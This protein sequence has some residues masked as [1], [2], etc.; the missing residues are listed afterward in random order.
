M[1][2]AL[3]LALLPLLG[4][5]LFPAAQSPPAEVAHDL[6]TVGS[7]PPSA[8]A[9]A[10]GST[11]PSLPSGPGSEVGPGNGTQR[12]LAPGGNMGGEGRGTSPLVPGA[13]PISA[14]APPARSSPKAGTVR[15]PLTVPDGASLLAQ[16]ESSLGG[17]AGP[18][19]GQTLSCEPV[20]VG[21][22]AACSS[23]RAVLS[24]KLPD[25]ASTPSW[26]ETVVPPQRS[27]A[28]MVYDAADGYVLLYGGSNAQ[29]STLTDTWKFLGGVWTPLSPSTY[30]SARTEESMTYDSVD[31]Y[32][33]LFGGLY[34]SSTYLGDTWKFVGGSW[35][36]L[37]SSCTITAREGAAMANDTA[38]GYVVL[39]GGYNGGY[40][41]DT[42]KFTGVS[43]TAL[44]PPTSPPARA[45]AAITY[46]EGDKYVVAY[47]GYGPSLLGD[48]WEFFGGS[49]T[50]ICSGLTC[51]LTARA[52]PGMAYDEVDRHVVLFGGSRGGAIS[53]TWTYAAGTWTQI[54]P[55]TPP[56]PRYQMGA[57]YDAQDGYVLLFAG[58]GPPGY[59][60]DTWTFAS[61]SWTTLPAE[62]SP[63]QRQDAS[64]T[65]DAA[66]G[67]VLLFGGYTR[68]DGM[69]GYNFVLSDTWKFVAGGWTELYPTSWPAGR[70]GAAMAYDA[71]DGY[72][73]LYGGYNSSG[74]GMYYDDT[75]KYLAG[76]WTQ[77]CLGCGPRDEYS[78]FTFDTIDNYLVAFGGTTGGPLQGT[79]KFSGGVWSTLGPASS[80]TARWGAA[81]AY[82]PVDHYVLLFGGYDGT[83][84]DGD[85]WKFLGG[86]WTS[87]GPSPVP[88]ARQGASMVGD[89]ADEYVVLF[90]G[91]TGAGPLS[92]TWKWAGN[93]WTA[94]SP[95]T[96]PPP[97]FNG[98]IADDVA[99]GY[100]VLFSGDDG[101]TLGD[102]WELTLPPPTVSAPTPSQAAADV[103]Q[104]FS[105]SA[106][107]NGGTGTYPTYTWT[108]SSVNLGCTLV[109]APSISCTPTVVGTSYTVSVSVTDSAG[110]SS[111]VATS[112]AYT[113][114]ADPTVSVP[115]GSPSSGGIDS[116]ETVTFSATSTPGSGGDTYVWNNLPTGCLSSSTLSLPCDP[117]TMAANATFLVSVTIKD[118]NGF[119][120]TGG[121]LSYLVHPA[122]SPRVPLASPGSGGVDD[123]Q[124]VTFS[125]GATLGTGSYTLWSWSGLPGCTG[126]NAPVLSCPTSGVVT[127]TTFTVAVTVTDSNGA[128]GTASLSYLVHPDP[129]VTV[130]AGTPSSVDSGGTVSFSEVATLGSGSYSWAWSG[131]PSSCTSQDLRVLPC[132][133]TGVVAN[134]TFTI[135]ATVTDSNGGSATSSSL[136][137]TVDA[138]PA[139]KVPVASSASGAVDSGQAVVF[140]TGATL[141]T[142]SYTT[143]GWSG[144]PGCPSSNTPVLSCLTGGVISNT[145]FTVTVTVT[146]SN[147]GSG[148]ASL[149]YLVHPAPVPSGISASPTSGGVDNGQT[150]TLSSGASLGTGSYTTWTWSGLPGCAPANSPV[151]SC[152]A[153][154]VVA[155]T[156]Y[157][158]SLVVTDSNGG[159]GTTSLV[160][161]VHPDP[162]VSAPVG[163]TSSVD[164]GQ[165]VAFSALATLGTG[166][167]TWSWSGL[168]TS[169]SS[170]DLRVLPCVP[171]GLAVNTTFSITVSVRDSNGGGAS[172]TSLSYTVEADPSPQGPVAAPVSGGVD[173]GQTVVFSSGGTLG[174][175]SYSSWSWSGLPGCPS[176]SSPVLSCTTSGVVANTSYT[177]VVTVTDSNG[178]SGMA[179][180]VYLVLAAPLPKVPSASPSS[181]GVDDGQTVT[182]STGATLGTGSYSFSWSGLPG[183]ASANT[184]VLTCTTSGVALNTTFSIVVVATDTNGGSGSASLFYLVHPDPVA[185]AP[186]ATPPSG[187]ADEGQTV[188]FDSGATLGTGVYSSWSWSGLPGC[189][190][191]NAPVVTCAV[192][193]VSA[194][195]TFTVAVTVVDSDGGSATASLSYLVHA[196]PVAAVPVASPGSGAV[197]DGQT[198]VLTTGA[199]QGT[200][201]YSLWSWSGLPG[202]ASVNAPTLSCT[203][204]GVSANTTYTISVTVTD[205]NG[206]SGSASLSYLVHPAPAPKAISASPA[207]GGVDAGQTVVFGSGASLGTGAYTAW[208][209]SGL[210]GCTSANL[211]VLS[212]TTGGLAVNTSY[213]VQIS[214]L[215]SNG[216][217]G[218]A[219]L[220]YLVLADPVAKVPVAAPV[221]GGVDNGQTVTFNAGATQGSGSYTTWS[222]S[223]LPGCSGANSPVLS[224]ATAG[225]ASNTTFTVAVTVSDSNGGS[226]TASLSY[227]VHPDPAITLPTGSPS[228]IDNGGTVQFSALATLGSGGYVWS[229][230]GL[231]SSC[232]SHDLRVLPCTPTGILANTT[233]SITATATDSNGNS[234]T[235]APFAYTVDSDPSIAGA[236]ASPD[237][238]DVGVAVQLSAS[239]GGGTPAYL[240]LWRC[241]DGFVASLQQASHSFSTPGSP[242]CE[243]WWNDSVG[244]SASQTLSVTV[245]SG[246]AIALAATTPQVDVGETA[247]VGGTVSGG[248]GPFVCTW[249][250]N[251]VAQGG[252]GCAGMS[253]LASSAGWLNFTATVADS[254]GAIGTSAL[255]AIPVAVRPS[256]SVSPTGGALDVGQSFV[257]TSSVAGGS[258]PVA[259]QWLLNGSAI[260]S[261]TSCVGYTFLPSHGGSYLLGIVAMDSAAPPR[262][263]W[264]NVS[265]NVS[266]PLLLALTPSSGVMD[267]GQSLLFVVAAAGGRA[268]YAQ[269]W[270]LN[271]TAISGAAGPSY[272][273]TPSGAGASYLLGVVVGDANGAQVWA[274]TSIA[275]DP[276][277]SVGSTPAGPLE[278]VVGS[279]VAFRATTAGGDL[280][281]SY[282]WYVNGGLQAGAPTATFTF[283][284]ASPGVFVVN[285]SVADALGSQATSTSTTV[286][287]VA[288]LVAVSGPA[289]AEVGVPSIFMA[290][291]EGGVGTLSYQWSV[292]GTPLAGASTS[293]L[294]FTPT[295]PGAHTLTVLVRDA[296]GLTATNSTTVQTVSRLAVALS[297][298]TSSAFV[299][300]TVHLAA[301]VTGGTGPYHFLWTLNG[302][303]IPGA[304]GALYNFTARGAG[305]YS[306]QVS[307]TDAQGVGATSPIL[308]L[309]VAPIPGPSGGKTKGPT[310]SEGPLSLP[311]LLGI[312][313]GIA[314][315]VLA[316]LV[317]LRR[318]RSS[319]PPPSPDEF[320][321]ALPTAPMVDAR[322]PTG[323]D[324]QAPTPGG[325]PSESPDDFD[326]TRPPL[327]KNQTLPAVGP[328]GISRSAAAGL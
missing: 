121:Q 32:V 321:D 257:L 7:D 66:D 326:P 301:L 265:I 286:D 5:P 252:T 180:L 157:T 8:R 186:S 246:P 12:N 161:V 33:L 255:L 245:G 19:Q 305:N 322:M 287:V 171:T 166:S 124:T 238:T 114:D 175:G 56:P 113:V 253:A 21:G 237:P 156:S 297:T 213:T 277:L 294:S 181:G 70:W 195:T 184:P 315:V 268:P 168:P 216:G 302:S 208:T 15:G 126:A 53:E 101:T 89:P 194:N 219:T 160:Y 163:S 79:W 58:G 95:S 200:G 260:A 29:S 85:T 215:D 78:S 162:S 74:L 90:G 192:S 87:L 214:V 60:G 48:T 304:T 94:W 244:G 106:T 44:S 247:S 290:S 312:L 165:S 42:W 226:G 37:C 174:T 137:Y 112:A 172:S 35:T 71:A 51:P 140:S 325:D 167:Y 17:G 73:V 99:D 291:V 148:S 328:P 279:S 59:L 110:R 299:R 300:W 320:A 6:P 107:A 159:T 134:T 52:A 50:E 88:S 154:G 231:P 26:T 104:T 282:R 197:D 324:T 150:L 199:T 270:Y 182:F 280:P 307:A 11:V 239:G 272:L 323:E 76:S 207:S 234:V 84:Y 20:H 233:F 146:D 306:F 228:V 185:R 55:A 241:T 46:D 187:G 266:A 240:F 24:P 96:S 138:D 250:V 75:W 93:A 91:T 129:A 251:G 45:Y 224:C 109:S 220:V 69:G 139:A 298:N 285:V 82:D 223:G 284:S 179:S 36:Q 63:S 68:V 248:L 236:S 170:Q 288:I 143:W 111:S 2:L 127:N 120:V 164:S 292:D 201:A 61:G 30:P 203:T 141:G 64:L 209:W 190:S 62:S 271:G 3:G 34:G 22:S 39:F 149:S 289:M 276:K 308:V 235:G 188:T 281:I 117:G 212:C 249:Y 81:M 1:I 264:S 131:L 125:T 158:I 153:S 319:T 83:T 77:L 25:G 275:V 18:A 204:A 49:W 65:Y 295:T 293:N 296:G 189:A 218:V 222:W 327:P 80:P 152:S 317:L 210:P 273:F 145:T 105:F 123:G 31:G 72:V 303:S 169:C 155:N 130:P 205:S 9:A 122:P 310:G 100:V 316:L 14:K 311:A 27:G 227:L 47:G 314:A 147:G 40:L 217:S 136:L 269:Q 67:Y 16:A 193:G 254:L 225:V 183:C 176:S 115:T 230:S 258:S 103:G 102:T 202:C 259:C 274:N 211:P 221:S 57:A 54:S 13:T 142:G 92:D 28:A 173:S 261:A 177:V 116:G 144:L 178:G 196:L 242:S 41:A 243:I 263:G 128:T 132:T 10:Q 118:S 151:L 86:Q 278:V 23:S 313:G 135:T 318:R 267:L 108:Q 97:R 229:W 43:W 309:T 262:S 256:V 119:S 191:A 38:D 206:G 283:S 232:T 98:A 4:Q 198:L 133:P